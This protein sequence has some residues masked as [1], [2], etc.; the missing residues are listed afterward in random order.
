M[1]DQIWVPTSPAMVFDRKCFLPTRWED[2]NF[3][4]GIARY[5][6]A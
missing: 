4:I 3:V 2:E 6:H 1:S 5:I